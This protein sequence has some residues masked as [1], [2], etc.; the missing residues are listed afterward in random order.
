MRV[1]PKSSG[2][3]APDIRWLLSVRMNR[4]L[5]V[6]LRNW[7]GDVVLSV[8]TLVRLEEAGY[9]LQLIGKGWAGDLLRGHGWPVQPLPK[10]LGERVRQLR[11]LR[12]E[13][14]A[15]DAGFERRINAVSFPYSFSSALD[16]R[17]AG[18]RAIGYAHEGRGFL[19]R[20]A[21]PRPKGGH[22][23][24]VYWQLGGALLGMAPGNDIAPP[25]RIGLRI[26]PEHRAQAAAL[27]ERH[28]IRPGYI[29]ICPFAGGTWDGRDKTWPGF[30]DFAAGPLRAFGR[31]V[32][33][34]PGPG[35]EETLAREKFAGALLLPGVGLGTY[36]AL[37]QGAALMISNDTGPGHMAAAVGAPLLSVL[38]P[39]NP[40][41]WGAW[42]PTAHRVGGPAAGQDVAPPNARANAADPPWPTAL[43][44]SE[45]V[46]VLLRPPLPAT[47]LV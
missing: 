18:L 34:C 32:L 2:E 45:T 35:A 11:G 22:E 41:L 6:R 47:T 38:G 17:L 1:R 25:E 39:S 23:L 28:G 36:A 4:P 15:N 19:L 40:A 5:I 27:R 7:V 14:R 30:A 16:M 24:A 13:A 42:G 12:R 9:D 31:Q 44:V 8:P 29:V 20:Q 10:P 37:L 26:A 46:A 33:I 3:I 21:V 43:Q